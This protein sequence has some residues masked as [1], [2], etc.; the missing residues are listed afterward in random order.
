MYNLKATSEKAVNRA[1]IGKTAQQPVFVYSL[2]ATVLGGFASLFFGVNFMT[3]GLLI[4]GLIVSVLGFATHYLMNKADYA[5]SYMAAIRQ[6]MF[7]RRQTVLQHLKKDLEAVKNTVGIGQITSFHNKYTN[8]ICILDK[9]LNPTELTYKRYLTIAE[10]V[11]FA[12]LDNLHNVALALKS[13]SAIDIEDV[14]KKLDGKIDVVLK[15]A[16][17]TRRQLYGEQNSRV[18]ELLAQNEHALTQLDHVTTKLAN[19]KTEQGHAVM[20]VK[21]AID[22]LEILIERVQKYSTVE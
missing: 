11:F 2:V 13:I 14:N 7:T 16:L 22:E 6:D 18:N 1:V 21:E 20:D 10:Q 17:E 5:N 8:L 4:S 15:E 12:G 19:I 9:K 3:F